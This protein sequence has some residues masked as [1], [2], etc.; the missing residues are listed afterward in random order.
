MD[1]TGIALGNSHVTR[2][3]F[4]TGEVVPTAKIAN[5]VYICSSYTKRKRLKTP[6]SWVPQ[7]SEDRNFNIPPDI[8]FF[9]TIYRKI[10]SRE[11]FYVVSEFYL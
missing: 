8:S 2:G 9:L 3:I 10:L 1:N 11:F 4:V 5:A 7:K 6:G